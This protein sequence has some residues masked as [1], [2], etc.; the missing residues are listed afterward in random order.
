MYLLI[1]SGNTKDKIAF[2][3]N[4]KI[5]KSFIYDKLSVGMLQKILKNIKIEKS[6]FCSVTNNKNINYFLDSKFNNCTLNHNTKTKIINNYSS[7]NSLGADR[8]ALVSGAKEIY[9]SDDIVVI[10]IGTCITYDFVNNKYEYFGGMIS[11]GY[12]LRLNVLHEKTSI[13]FSG[14]MP[15]K[16]NLNIISNNSE[17]CVHSGIYFGILSEIN[18][19]FHLYNQNFKNLKFIF[20]GGNYNYFKNHLKF[21]HIFDENLI[22]KGLNSILKFNE[23]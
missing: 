6:I 12:E 1:D 5:I 3:E 17:N 21:S 11:P 7:K 22:F 15:K 14:V 20:T 2:V 23:G 18:G 13:Q 4:D 16:M 10:D 19:I 9:P 8:I